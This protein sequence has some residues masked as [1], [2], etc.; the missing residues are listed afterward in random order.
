MLKPKIFTTLQNYT[1][2]QFRSDATAGFIVG[3]VA[4][5]LCI[6]FAIAS[7]LTPE[8]GLVT[9]VVAGLLI[10]LLGGSRVQ[11]GGPAGAFIVIVAG[12]V[13]Q[14]GVSGLITA[15]LMAGIILVAMGLAGL[16]SVIKFIPQPVITGFTSGIAV[17]IFASQI[18][19]FL[20]LTLPDLATD[21]MERW[22]RVLPELRFFNPYALSIAAGT[23]L[24][25][26]NWPKISHRIPGPL[27]ALI[28]STVA[29][30]LFQLPVETIGERFGALPSALPEPVLPALSYEVIRSL[31][32]PAFAIAMLGAIE[33]LLSAVVADGMIG[34]R[35]RSNMEL[36]AQGV[37]N[38]F[39]AI[40]GG[41]PATGAIARTATNVRNGGR[42]PIAGI[43]HALTL[44]LI[45]LF[46]ARWAS[47]IPLACLAGILVL[48]AYN[49]FEWH[50]FAA[51]L[52]SPRGDMAVLLATFGLTILVD[53]VVAIE[54]GMV[55]AAFLFMK[56]MSEVTNVQVLKREFS[57]DEEAETVDGAVAIPAG[58]EV[59]EINGPF[60][61]GAVYKFKEAM[62]VV[63]KAPP[64]RILRMERVSALDSSGLSALEEVWHDCRKHGST[65]LISE[66]HAQPFI[67]LEKSGLLKQ[68][69][70][71]NVLA[72]YDDALSRAR[73]ILAES[74]RR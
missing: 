56:H 52:K 57:E 46:F 8:R 6:A 39:S 5:P 70:E 23:I 10:S 60:F 48:V 64:V 14:Y 65:F 63:E 71:Q 17:I 28:A 58:V 27:V 15:T 9:G 3:I 29:V 31:V 62:S 37:A 47:L 55:M 43:V 18:P 45:T 30:Q 25:M 26:I 44:L 59:Y 11:I 33:S 51:I 24:I 35:H 42:T 66:I 34:A 41:M 12:I 74:A 50:S 73:E 67:A 13:E 49:M 20:G 38:F 22:A 72:N 68:F 19:D 21:F 16:G 69:G 40:F 4:L 2:Q 53:L 1:A 54:V 32:Q 61:F 36:V 7:G